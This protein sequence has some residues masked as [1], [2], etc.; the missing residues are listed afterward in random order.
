M[1]TG[2][3][4]DGEFIWMVVKKSVASE[5]FN[6]FLS[7]VTYALTHKNKHKLKDLLITM[8]TAATHW[9]N[10]TKL[11]I[12]DLGLSVAYLPPYW[13]FLATVEILF[14][15]IKTNIRSMQFSR[16]VDYLK[17]IQVLIW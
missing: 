3:G 1:I 12:E 15:V 7:V 2:F 11:H 6:E 4:S 13:S 10:R 17:K 5:E 9:S 8:D 16:N 14:K